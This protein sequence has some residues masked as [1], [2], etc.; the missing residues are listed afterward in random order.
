MQ[1]SRKQPVGEP[2]V[3]L[4]EVTTKPVSATHGSDHEAV[5]DVEL[6]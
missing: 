6:A 3:L 4:D 1:A 2:I 5:G